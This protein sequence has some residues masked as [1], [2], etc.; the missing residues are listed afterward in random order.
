MRSGA[1]GQAPV[2]Q[3]H[4]HPQMLQFLVLLQELLPELPGDQLAADWGA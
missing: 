2:G 4:Q 1:K 3:K